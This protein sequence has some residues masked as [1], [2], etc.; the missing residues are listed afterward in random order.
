MRTTQ[1]ERKKRV[2]MQTPNKTLIIVSSMLLIVSFAAGRFFAPEKVRVETKTVEVDK[3]TDDKQS[4]VKDHK[5]ITIVEKSG[6]DGTKTKTTTITD[7]KENS[8]ADHSTDS[9][10]KYSDTTKEVS[11]SHSPVSVSLLASDNISAPA[12]PVY[13]LAIQRPVLGPLT[14]GIFAFTNRTGGVSIGLTF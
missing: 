11:K 7:D 14:L 1:V 12:P 5:K 2:R 8:T 9:T 10:S 3:K 13:G 6:P 4:D